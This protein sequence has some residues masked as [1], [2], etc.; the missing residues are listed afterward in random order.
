MIVVP[1][2]R[3]ALAGRPGGRLAETLLPPDVAASGLVVKVVR[4]PAGEGSPAGLHQH[5]FDQVFLVLAG[6]MQVEAEGERTTAGPGAVV[7][8]PAGED[9]RN[10]NE[11]PGDTEHIVLNIPVAAPVTAAPSPAPRGNS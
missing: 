4:T 1:D 3:S 6:T 9:H 10:W 8:F 2:P 7:L 5:A 11:G